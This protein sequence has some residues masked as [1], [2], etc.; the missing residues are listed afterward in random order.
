MR[1][2]AHTCSTPCASPP[3][4]SFSRP[5]VQLLWYL[6]VYPTLAE[7]DKPYEVMQNTGDVIFVPRGWWHMVLN[8]TDTVSVTQNFVNQQNLAE[9]SVCGPAWALQYSRHCGHALLCT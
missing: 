4:P 9:V 1:V 7:E 2:W 5:N 6:E 8:I 3:L